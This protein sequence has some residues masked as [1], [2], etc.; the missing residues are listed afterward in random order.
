MMKISVLDAIA[1]AVLAAGLFLLPIYPCEVNEHEYSSFPHYVKNKNYILPLPPVLVIGNGFQWSEGTPSVDWGITWEYKAN[2][3][4]VPLLVANIIFSGICLWIFLRRVTRQGGRVRSRRKLLRISVMKGAF[5]FILAEL[6]ILTTNYI[7]GI[8][9]GPYP[10]IMNW[11]PTNGDWALD[12]SNPNLTIT[13]QLE[14]AW[15][16]VSIALAL[17]YIIYAILAFAVKKE[18]GFAENSRPI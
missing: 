12:F 13:N 8:Y 6:F 1:F 16:Y 14:W 9:N 3:W 10:H 5:F 15:C 2:I 7:H 11:P 17:A 4:F 18:K